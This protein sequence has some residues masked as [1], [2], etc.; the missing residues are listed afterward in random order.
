MDNN[1]RIDLERRLPKRAMALILAGGRG[2]RLKQLTDT[3]CKPAVYFGGHFRINFKTDDGES[4]EVGGRY[5]EVTPYQRLIFSWAW[6]S[7]PE[8]ISQVTV[9]LR[10]EGDVTLLTLTHDKF[11]DEAARDGHKRGWTGTLDKLEKFFA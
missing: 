4:H 5:L 9:V 1:A 10:E 3:R 7:T 2:S 8:R 6:H 11:F